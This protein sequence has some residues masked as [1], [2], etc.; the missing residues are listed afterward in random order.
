MFLGGVWERLV[1]ENLKHHRL[2]D[3]DC[4]WRKVGRWWGTSLDR[5]PMEVD[6]VAESAD[7]KRLLIGEAKL[8]LTA[9]EY[10]YE[11]SELRRKAQNLPFAKN[12]SDI[13]CRLFVAENKTL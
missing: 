5:K 3:D 4:D 10:E 13:Q 11:L 1:R 2:P 9:K 7:G 12:Y 8:K 6:V